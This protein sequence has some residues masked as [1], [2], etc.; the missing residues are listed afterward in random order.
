MAFAGMLLGTVFLIVLGVIYGIAL[1]EL[2]VGIILLIKK[3]KV[4]A[5][6]LLVLSAL[7]VV[8]TVIVLAIAFFKV[9][10]PQYD[11]YDGGS[12]T[13]RMED[14]RIMRNII[15]TGDMEGLDEFVDKHPELIYY[16]DNNHETLLEYGLHSR[17]VEIMEI[18]VEH[19]AKFDAEPT[20]RL[21]VYDYSLEHFF[22]TGYPSFAATR[23]DDM[24]DDNEG[25]ATDEMIEAAR[26]AV[27][28]GAKTVWTADVG[29]M[30]FADLVEHWINLDNEI[31]AKDEEFLE[32][33]RSLNPDL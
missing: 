29:R 8:I 14:V 22:N 17:N 25:V 6:V 19:G 12:V 13:V 2:I 1:I 32:Y 24:P 20:Y 27:D 9:E 31:S 5:I 26:F 4:P 10:Y 33:A 15:R 11:T 16:Q 21:L 3:K 18:A 7:P 30:T 23:A 28:H